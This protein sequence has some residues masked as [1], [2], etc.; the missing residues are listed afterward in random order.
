VALV[1]SSGCGK[2]TIIALLMRFY[3]V[4][5]GGIYLD[6]INI[7]DYDLNFLRRCFGLVS[8]EP[9]LFNGTIDYNIKYVREDADKEEVRH[10]AKAANALEFIEK[11][12]F[13]VAPT[14]ENNAN[15]GQGFQRLVGPKGSQISGGQKQRIAI[16]RAVINN[17]K[18]LLLDEATS[19]LDSKNEEIVQQSLDNIMKGYT[20]VTIAHRLSTIKDADAIYVFDDGKIAEKGDFDLLMEKKGLFW[21]LAE[22]VA[23]QDTIKID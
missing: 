19:A 14:E 17:P 5:E 20:S 3:D 12:Q 10:A 21:A 18:I 9:V 6:D 23:H 8:Q 7:K 16:A 4:Q 11:N 2:S 1:G 13:E 22:G 15:Y